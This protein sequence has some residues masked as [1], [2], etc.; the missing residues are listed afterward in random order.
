M[1]RF[2]HC[3]FLL[4][5]AVLQADTSD[6]KD[7]QYTVQQK[8]TVWA[9]CKNYVADSLCWKKLVEYNQIKNPKYLPP[10]SILKI[11][12]AWLK[13]SVA[14]AVV[15]SVEGEVTV[16]SDG[17]RGSRKLK[18]NDRLSQKD[19][20]V[21]NNGSAMIQFADQ[22]RLL[23][24]PNSAIRMQGLRYFRKG[25]VA[26]TEI[27][28][29]RGRVKANVKKFQGLKSRFDISTPAAVA[30]VRGTEYRV[31]L[32]DQ[33]G[34]KAV[35]LTELL[36]GQVTVQSQINNQLLNAGEAVKAIEGKGVGK[37]VKLLP[38]PRLMFNQEKDIGLPYQLT[39]H[40][41]KGA[42]YYRVVFSRQGAILRE[43]RTKQTTTL[44]NVDQTGEYELY[45]SGVDQYG[46]EGVPRRLLLNAD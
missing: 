43:E 4:W 11:P 18:V 6:S 40:P 29:L 21:A 34:G 24:K 41:L 44:V 42:V 5:S 19:T 25:G 23:L 30:A 1:S 35:M 22:S 26:K 3:V 36:E 28:L 9:V 10:G 17:Q 33:E 27:R 2:V 32:T 14:E 37:P 13:S 20:V 39:W 45:L 7:W 38:R 12:R 46:F 16:S 31:S 8:D 15:I